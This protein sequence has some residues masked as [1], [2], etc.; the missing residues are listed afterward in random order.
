MG[1]KIEIFYT[2]ACPVCPM[3]KRLVREILP[4]FG[5]AADIEVEEV[6]AWIQM[7]RAAKYGLVAVPA[8]AINGELRFMGL[9]GRRELTVAIREALAGSTSI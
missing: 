9:P 6:D 5:P 1:V 3:A 4:E 2:P 8:I 7:D